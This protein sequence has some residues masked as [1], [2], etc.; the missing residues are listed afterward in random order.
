MKN[1]YPY[2]QLASSAE[3]YSYS[4]EQISYTGITGTFSAGLGLAYRINSYFDVATGVDL[5]LRLNSSPYSYQLT[6][7]STKRTYSPAISIYLGVNF[8]LGNNLD[9]TVSY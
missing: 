7:D 5:L 8:N 3:V 4:V 9:T 6:N 1:V 2:C